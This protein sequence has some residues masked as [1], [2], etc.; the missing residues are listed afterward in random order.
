VSHE[1][2]SAS[3]GAAGAYAASMPVSAEAKPWTIARAPAV[4]VALAMIAGIAADRWL[5]V[6]TTASVWWGVGLVLASLLARERASL[7][8]LMLLLACGVLGLSSARVASSRFASDEIAHFVDDTP[9]LVRLR[10]ELDQEPRWRT[11][12]FGQRTTLPARQST[13][14][15][16]REV[17]TH[18]GWTSASGKLLLN[19]ADAT[20]RIR[21]G[22]MIEVLAMLDRPSPA[23]NPGQFDWDRYYRGQ[24]ILASAQVRKPSAIRV[25]AEES[26]PILTRLHEAARHRLAA[27]FGLDR[28]LD[29]ALVQALV[30]GDYDPELRD[31][32]EQ[33]RKTGTSHH[34]AISGAHLAVIG[35]IVFV[36]A[37][38][39]RAT[40]RSCWIVAVATVGL[41]GLMVAPSAPVWRSVILFVCAAF[42]FVTRRGSNPLQ[43]LA[44]AACV[45]LA[46]N[47]LDLFNAGFQLSFGIVAGMVLLSDPLTTR[48]QAGREPMMPGEIDLKPWPIRLGRHADDWL[49]KLA[50]VTFIA[51]VVSMPLVAMNFSRLNLWQMLASIAIAPFVTVSLVLGVSKLLL[52]TLLPWTASGHAWLTA[53]A[54]AQMRW[55][56]GQLSRLPWS[57]VPLPSPPA[58][59]VVLCLLTFMRAVMPASSAVARLGS[60]GACVACFALLFIGPFAPRSTVAASGASVRVTLLSVGAGQCAIIEPPDGR[61]V[62]IDCG[63]ASLTDVVGSTVSPALR[64]L[65]HTSVDTI[66]VSHANLDH[67]SGVA[68]LVSAYRAREVLVARGFDDHA[69]RS[70][71][72]TGLSR[73]LRVLGR[74]PRFTRAGDS[75]PLGP[76]TT[77]EVLWP[78]ERPIDE[79]NDA[80]I[81]LRLVHAGGSVLFTG[82]VAEAS[83]R[84]MVQLGTHLDA[85]VLIAPHH[86]SFERSTRDFLDA[87]SP[88]V[89]LASNARRLSGKQRSFDQAVG[90]IPLYRTHEH[91][92]ITLTI[93]SRGAI[94]IQ[95]FLPGRQ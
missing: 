92:A 18:D 62:V 70:D 23:V 2:D 11:R 81:V 50:A 58:W 90:A 94:H 6:S 52:T 48:L 5:E 83:M 37:R 64:E 54:S 75:I 53:E 38:L 57:D 80:S 12:T 77:L 7:A 41:Y 84:E 3:P 43:W 21:A 17:L 44:L 88:Q 78:D 14:A 8:T 51:W 20:P 27:G 56:V 87:V 10:L 89:I 24:R 68:E 65:G 86:G 76:D 40:P 61:V 66:I 42:A 29:H 60:L 49:I 85:D 34:L 45:L 36:L 13:V 32:S 30:L 67:Y 25:L 74:P 47:P 26:P 72:G 55:A 31:I 91:G 4:P 28:S 95:P 15:R 73:V 16:V 69:A 35:G 93:D 19:I 9:R 46:L 63:S 59:L 82:D 1:T 79:A 71:T 33:F 22:Q 39:V